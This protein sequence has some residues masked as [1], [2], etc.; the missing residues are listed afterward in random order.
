[1]KFSV[2]E[3]W[4]T[5]LASLI[6]TPMGDSPAQ[7]P[8]ANRLRH[9]CR[10]RLRRL[11]YAK[12]M[13]TMTLRWSLL[14]VPVIAMLLADT[15]PPKPFGME[16]RVKWT[17]SR[18]VGSPDPPPK[19]RLTRAFDRFVFKEPVFIAQD[20]ASDQ[21]GLFENEPIEGDRKST[22]LNSSHQ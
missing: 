8:Q 3:R 12:V 14:C 4:V 19:Y 9:P 20:P 22:R 11:L 21:N 1:M 6:S 17:T 16:K 15:G 7:T 18:L 5:N 10:R 13:D 2:K